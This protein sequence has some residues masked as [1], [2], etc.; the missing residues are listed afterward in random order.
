V[1]ATTAQQ[2]ETCPSG[3]DMPCSS[4]CEQLIVGE[5]CGVV[6]KLRREPFDVLDDAG[7]SLEDGSMIYSRRSWWP[8]ALK[9]TLARIAVPVDD[10]HSGDVVLEPAVLAE[11]T[12][13][14]SAMATRSPAS[15]P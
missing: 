8:S 2:P 15:T 10:D 13:W 11:T 14:L 6:F 1:T 3:E 12:A 5:G 4:R 9:P 7:G